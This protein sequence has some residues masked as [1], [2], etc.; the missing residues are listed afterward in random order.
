[1]GSAEDLGSALHG[2]FHLLF[3]LLALLFGV[4]RSHEGVFAQAVPN[5]DF[6]GFFNQL[7]HES[8]GDVVKQV[9]AFHR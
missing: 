1:L 6:L 3:D 9:E 2:I 8:V 5:F 4:Q 7:L